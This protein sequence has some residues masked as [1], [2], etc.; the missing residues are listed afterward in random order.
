MD[1]Y[2]NGIEEFLLIITINNYD[3]RNLR[4]DS[5]L[6]IPPVSSIED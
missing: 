1:R 6:I 4:S 3:E 2:N 5:F